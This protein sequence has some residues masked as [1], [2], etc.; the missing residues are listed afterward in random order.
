MTRNPARI[1]ESIGMLRGTLRERMIAE[2]RLA[3]AGEYAVPQLLKVLVDSKDSALELE[4]TKRLVEL[5]R[6]AVLPLSMSLANLDSTSQRKVVAILGEI[7]WPTAIPFILEVGASP[8]EPETLRAA[9][10]AAFAQ[11]NG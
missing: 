7:G 5:K 2:E 1:A 11:L 8:N 10:D 3:A 6:Q 4:A 9:C